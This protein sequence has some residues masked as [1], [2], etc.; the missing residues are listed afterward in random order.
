MSKKCMK[1]GCKRDVFYSDSV[2]KQCREIE[3]I[4]T[5]QQLQE[6]HNQLLEE[7]NQILS[8][9]LG[10]FL[11]SDIREKYQKPRIPKSEDVSQTK[12][13]SKKQTKLEESKKMFIPS[14]EGGETKNVKTKKSLADIDINN[15]A[16]KLKKIEE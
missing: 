16:S 6:K 8:Q 12:S 2:C 15:I 7:Q 5:N 9:I 4:L 3:S 14:I 10:L 1:P 13:E 11:N